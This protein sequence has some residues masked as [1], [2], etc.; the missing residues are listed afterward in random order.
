VSKWEPEVQNRDINQVGGRTMRVRPVRRAAV[1]RYP[2]RDYLCDHPE[3]LEL[4]PERWRRNGLVLAVLG[5]VVSLILAC[6][7]QAAGQQ[8]AAAP[9]TTVDEP[10]AASRPVIEVVQVPQPSSLPLYIAE[11]ILTGQVLSSFGCMAINPPMYLTEADARQVLADEVRRAPWKP[12]SG[13]L[14]VRAIAYRDV[15]RYPDC[16]YLDSRKQNSS[17]GSE[18]SGGAG[19]SQQRAL[20]CISSL[21]PGKEA[22]VGIFY[23]RGSKRTAAKPQERGTKDK[24]GEAVSKAV[25][26][27]DNSSESEQLRRQVRDFIQWLKAQGVI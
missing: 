15:G 1:P 21:I 25:D 4:V 3:L 26:R 16:W 20:G 13:A 5:G 12:A 6:Q 11:H 2:T 19:S 22:A 23:E 27:L 17:P 18:E 10:P 7:A 24:N 9:G 14:T 8:A